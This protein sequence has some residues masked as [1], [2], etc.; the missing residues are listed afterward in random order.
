MHAD[1]VPELG[2]GPVLEVQT[3]AL[4]LSSQEVEQYVTVPIE[5]NLLDGIMDVW[6]VRSQSQPGLSTVDLYFEPGTTVLHARQ[7]VTE[8]LTNAFELPNIS[9]PPQLIQ[10]LSSTSRVLMVGLRSTTLDSLELS[11][12]ARWIVKPRLSGVPGVANVSIFGQ[13]DRQIQ[14]LVDPARLAA[15]GVTLSQIIQTA[16]NAQLVSP[17]S[18]LEGSSPGTGGFLDGPNQRLEVRPVLPLGAPSDLATVPVTGTSRLR[19]GNLATVVQGNQPLIGDANVGGG[20]GLV[21]MVQK[22]PS[23]SVLSVTRGLDRALQQLRP[24]LAGV[25]VD[26][27]FFRPARYVSGALDNL[28]IAALI[29]LALSLVALAALLLR[30]RA[31]LVCAISIALS[32]L[33]AALVL[34]AL[35]ETFNALTIAGLLIA[36]AI[37]VDDAVSGTDALVGAITVD[38]GTNGRSPSVRSVVHRYAELRGPLSYATLFILVSVAPVFFA[39]GL[40]ATFVHPLVLAFSV[41]VLTSMAG[42]LIFTPALGWLLLRPGVPRPRADAL[43]RRAGAAYAALVGGALRIPRVL[44]GGVLAFGLAGVVAFP[45]LKQPAAPTFVDRNL[46]VQWSGPAG[47]SL[48]EMDRITGRVVG[49]LRALPAVADAAAILGRA[50]GGDQ[51]VD[52][53]SG[54]IMVALKPSAD[55]ARALG[56]VRAIV[57]G[58]PGMRASVSTYE[59]DVMSG[60]LAPASH[61][62]TVRF[63]GEDYG[64]LQSL[65]SQARRLMALIPGLGPLRVQSPAMEPNIEVAVNDGAALRAGVL[66]GDA[67]RQASTLVSGLTVGNFFEHQAVFDVTV[68]GTPAVRSTLD[69]VRKLLIDTSGGGH[70]PLSQ[71][72]S[73]GVHPDPIVI[74]HQALSRYIDLT[75]PVQSGG[76]AAAQSAIQA[77]LGSIRYPLGYH[78][79]IVGGTPEDATSHATFISFAL[80]AAIG[81]LLLAQAALRSWRLAALFLLALPAA[82]LGGVLVALATGQFGSLGCDVGLIAVFGIATR[83]G[84][85]QIDRLRREHA[86]VG[87]ELNEAIIV[88]AAGRRLAPSATA[89]AVTAA[90]MV[91]FVVMGNVAGNEITHAAAA[92]ILGGLVT[93]ALLVGLLLPALCLTFGPATPIVESIEEPIEEPTEQPTEHADEQATEAPGLT[94]P[95]MSPQ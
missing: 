49:Q 37:V 45:F 68:R 19:L 47:A 27:A 77:M 84:L 50:V 30:L 54:Q 12:L 75:A 7:L 94:V 18:Y 57:E 93:S 8:R 58:T 24:A 1:V 56:Q 17:L 67:R 51:I 59:S 52:T 25:Q 48:A 33:S 91:P 32:L 69:N 39:K 76:T 42:A 14:V 88:A 4:G 80:A 5:N 63:Y 92:V 55:Y 9:K 2:S 95:T 62:V 22:L 53:S 86:R 11:Y 85:L 90:V 66:A 78:A 73:V 81:L 70:V 13:R 72:A 16:G 29:A 36:T 87:G 15:R 3:E 41:A 23:A 79:E 20:S 64:Q 89:L 43:R 26:T 60:V 65:A 31:L 6:D 82:L 10:P 38:H 71:I 44:L 21:L 40:S 74:R 83:Q 46:V 34:Q 61:E 35:G 28:A